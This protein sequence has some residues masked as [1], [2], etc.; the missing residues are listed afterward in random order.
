ML[1]ILDSIC[2]FCNKN[3]INHNYEH[4]CE[5]RYDNEYY[6]ELF[7]QY[8]IK[9]ELIRIVLTKHM[10]NPPCSIIEEF[11]SNIINHNVTTSYYLHHRTDNYI[12][13]QFQINCFDIFNKSESIIDFYTTLKTLALFA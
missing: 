11:T 4:V 6:F 9:N 3:Q 1:Y 5:Q 7:T 12:S 8:T 10:Y 2:K 13:Q